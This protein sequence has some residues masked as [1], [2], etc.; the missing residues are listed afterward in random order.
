MG[1]PPAT[2]CRSGR[3]WQTV[4][5][6]GRVNRRRAAAGAQGEIGEG[7]RSRPAPVE[8]GHSVFVTGIGGA[9]RERSEAQRMEKR[10]TAD[11]LAGVL[12]REL[13]EFTDGWPMEWRKPVGGARVHMAVE[14]RVEHGG[15]LLDGWDDSN[16]LTGAG[17]RVGG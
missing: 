4:G 14:E 3:G 15:G 8:N 13:Y 2:H 17:R 16:C 5:T 1:H 9:R 6:Q 10:A 11:E 7:R 12:C